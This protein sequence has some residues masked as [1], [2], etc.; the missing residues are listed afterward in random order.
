MRALIVDDERHVLE[1]LQTMIPWREIGIAEL[2]FAE[3]GEAGWLQYSRCK[4]DLVITDMNMKRMNGI[5]LIRRIREVDADIPILVLSGYDDFAYTKT[6]IQLN[7]TRYILKPSLPEEIEYE[8]R[9]VIYELQH[10]QREKS[11]FADLQKQFE[12][13]LPS[14]REQLLHQIVTAGFQRQ[15]IRGKLEFYQ[16]HPAT[17]DSGLVMSVKVYKP[18]KEERIEEGQWQLYKFAVSNIVEEL[19]GHESGYLLRYMDNRLSILLIGGSPGSLI[20]RAARLGKQI[21]DAVQSYLRLDLN[22]GIGHGCTD[23]AR[24]VISF[25][26]SIEALELGELEG[27]NQIY[28]YSDDEPEPRQRVRYPAD[29][30]Q[31]LGERLLDMDRTATLALW[32]DIRQS[33]A[34]EGHASLAYVHTVCT[35]I[36]TNLILKLLEYDSRLLDSQRISD[37]LLQIHQ[38]RT[39]DNLMGWMSERIGELCA[40]V[41]ESDRDQ[42]R[43]SYVDYVKKA[44]A[45]RYNRKISFAELA[46]ELNI[47]R[48]YLSNLFKKETGVSFVSYLGSY[49]AAKAKALLKKKRY[50]VYEIAEMVGYQDPA[51]FSRMFKSVTGMSPLEYAMKE[52]G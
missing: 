51:Y 41:A 23:A 29:Q 28:V 40:A 16:L 32:A 7:V 12:R 14:L 21:V 52:E 13:S 43:L 47:N 35:G 8:I 11:M 48:N 4:P 17:F 50:T 42:S 25:R 36:L 49:R 30:I 19:L 5:E 24:Y 46:K 20:E 34:G 39:L 33:L 10:K 2:D 44:V 38:N 27:V 3:D 26:E 15:D 31:L 37:M 1:G 45:E 9:D 6:A 18:A 22:V